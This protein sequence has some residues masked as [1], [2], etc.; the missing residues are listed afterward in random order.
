MKTLSF[1]VS[2]VATGW[3]FMDDDKIIAYDVICP[4][5]DLSESAKYFYIAHSAL[6][7]MKL[8]R[9]RDVV[10]EDTF[11]AKDPTVLKKLNRIAGQIMLLWFQISG[12][13]AVFYMAMTAR[14]DFPGLKGTSKKEEIVEAVNKHFNLRGRLK[15]HNI[16]DALV[17]GYHYY[18]A[19]RPELGPVEPTVTKDT[20]IKEKPRKK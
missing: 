1:D 8:Y 2:T 14:K 11:F 20:D 16:A 19:N 9:P 7:L 4:P 5:D 17:L 3:A 13:E 15:D 12:H 10:I 18:L 6:G